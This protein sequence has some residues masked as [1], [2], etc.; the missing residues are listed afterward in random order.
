MIARGRVQNGV[1]VLDEG[2]R[3]P[4]GQEV[5]VLGRGTVPAVPAL[6]GA[7]KH[8]VLDIPVVSL[9]PV[10]RTPTADDDLLGEMLEGRP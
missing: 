4:E 6:Q 9:G 5:T 8:S 2:V 7:P 10:L 3:L 1:V